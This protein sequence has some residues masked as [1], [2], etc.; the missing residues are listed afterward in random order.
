[1][2]SL[3]ATV[4]P[5]LSD[6]ADYRSVRYVNGND[7]RFG[8]EFAAFLI[9]GVTGSGK[10]EVYMDAIARVPGLAGRSALFAAAWRDQT[11]HS[12]DGYPQA[13]FQV[14]MLPFC[15]QL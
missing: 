14:M 8:S 9:H 5:V 10:T 3:K 2:R 13:R 4:Q 12:G 6:E 15:T 1:M 7:D 11:E